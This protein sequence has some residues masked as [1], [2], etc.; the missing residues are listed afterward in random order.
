MRRSAATARRR[1]AAARQIT[2]STRQNPGPPVL[3][4]DVRT[5]CDRLQIT[6]E[7]LNAHY[8]RAVARPDDTCRP[9]TALKCL[10]L[11]TRSL[12]R[13]DAARHAGSPD[14]SMTTATI[15]SKIVPRT[16]RKEVHR[17]KA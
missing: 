2:T 11:V 10:Y 12:D 5:P 4:N 1:G 6:I 8:R 14:A 13:P 15:F 17:H 7:S 9:N 3:V 16:S